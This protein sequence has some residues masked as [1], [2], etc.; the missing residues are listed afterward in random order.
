MFNFKIENA[1]INDL[2]R[3]K[4][5]KLKTIIKYAKNLSEE[6]MV[7]INN[8]ICDSVPSLI[9]EYKNIIYNKKII[10]SI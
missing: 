6:E 10:G 4:Y 9:K 3:I 8:Y 7:K 5:Y 1:T 2:E